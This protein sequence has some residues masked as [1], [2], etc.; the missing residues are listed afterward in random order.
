MFELDVAAVHDLQRAE[1]LLAEER[2]T[3]R[4]VGERRQRRNRRT[5]TGES[6]KV[7]FQSPDR[8]NDPRLDLVL[9]AH[10]VQ[11]VAVLRV[12]LL[13]G[14]DA[15]LGQPPFEIRG[16]VERELG[17]RAVALEDLLDRLDVSEGGVE[18]LGTDAARQG[19]RAQSASQASKGCG[20]AAGTS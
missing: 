9:L 14:E 15:A 6:S 13:R 11:K 16:E 8:G 4:I 19:L 7:R 18:D 10:R 17:L 2:R 12:H 1:E 3:P 5:D 20:G